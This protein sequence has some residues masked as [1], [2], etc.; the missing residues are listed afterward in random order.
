MNWLCHAGETEIGGFG[1]TPEPGR[2]LVTEFHLITQQCTPV[3]V[4]FDDE[5]VGDYF[6]RR[7]DEG[8]KPEQFARLWLHT[9]PADC[10]LPSNTDEETFQRVFGS[11]DWAIMFILARGGQTYA[12][13]RFGVGPGG[14]MR[15][16]I[17]IRWDLPIGAIDEEG[18]TEEYLANVHDLDELRGT[19]PNWWDEP[20][21]PANGRADPREAVEVEA[22]DES[23]WRERQEVLDACCF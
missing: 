1:I 2:L 19:W 13:L 20:T 5:A 22:I 6:E 23:L 16:P 3:F 4:S 18:W 14:Q 10:A 12:R 15:I 8:Y 21:V 9:H 17:G 7:V 11:C